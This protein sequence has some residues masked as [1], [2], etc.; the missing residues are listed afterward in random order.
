MQLQT[1]LNIALISLVIQ[2][3]VTQNFSHYTLKSATFILILSWSLTSHLCRDLISSPVVTS[4]LLAFPRTCQSIATHLTFIILIFQFSLHSL[5]QDDLKYSSDHFTPWFKI[6]TKEQMSP[7][8][9]QHSRSFLMQIK[10]CLPS[11]S[12]HPLLCFI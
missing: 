4:P 11:L 8:R 2:S 5:R 6:F 12:F 9:K 10:P 7:Y 1:D 3:N